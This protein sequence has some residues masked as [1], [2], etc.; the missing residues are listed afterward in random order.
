MKKVVL[1]TMKGC[2][3]CEKMKEIL[4]ENNI[5]YLEKDIHE[6]EYEYDLFVEATNNEYIPSFILMTLKDNNPHN[7]KLL[8]PERDFDSIEEAYEKVKKYLK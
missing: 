7:I 3:H 6:Y 2:P 4:N 8:A 1:F 5:N